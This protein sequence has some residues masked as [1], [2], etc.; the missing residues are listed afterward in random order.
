ML[1]LAAVTHEAERRLRDLYGSRLVSIGYRE[2]RCDD[3][4]GDEPD[5][6]LLAVLDGEFDRW[7]EVRRMSEIA[8]AAGAPSGAFLLILPLTI[9][10]FDQPPNDFFGEQIR[11]AS[12]ER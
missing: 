7:A 2:A 6:E 1:D 10:E 4:E 8:S 3:E 5:V 11:E 9:D 12:F